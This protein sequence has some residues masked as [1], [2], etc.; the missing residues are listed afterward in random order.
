MKL[1][2]LPFWI[3]GAAPFRAL[4]QVLWTSVENWMSTV[5]ES[6]RI[7]HVTQ[8][9]LAILWA[10]VPVRPEGLSDANKAF[11]YQ[12]YEQVI[13]LV[14]TGPGL[15]LVGVMFQCSLRHEALRDGPVAAFYPWT[16]VRI[17]LPPLSAAQLAEVDQF[18]SLMLPAR[19][20]PNRQL[21]QLNETGGFGVAPFGTL[22]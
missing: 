13:E 1:P 12:Y 4:A 22:Y 19:C 8:T 17:W 16:A 14:G 9:G 2:D 6:G 21:L 18:I 11:F 3:K 20:I 10:D 15:D 5:F 7:M